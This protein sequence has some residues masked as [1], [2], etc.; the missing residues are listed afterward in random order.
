MMTLFPIS[1]NPT[2]S[3]IHLLRK[4]LFYLRAQAQTWS[5]SELVIDSS[6]AFRACIPGLVEKV[7]SAAVCRCV[8]AD[9]DN[10]P[11]GNSNVPGTT[12]SVW[13]ACALEAG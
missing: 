12:L 4:R 11:D 3:L 5:S 13:A 2:I 7:D 6:W 8:D 9:A 1:I 10:E